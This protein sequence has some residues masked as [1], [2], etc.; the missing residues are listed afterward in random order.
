MKKEEEK[1]GNS[2]KQTR[3][4]NDGEETEGEDREEDESEKIGDVEFPKLQLI[5]I[6]YLLKIDSFE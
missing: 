3:D 1:D 6:S 4:E 2:H 5:K